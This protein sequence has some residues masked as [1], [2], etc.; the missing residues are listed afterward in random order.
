[1]NVWSVRLLALLVVALIAV[2]C[3]SVGPPA[4]GSTPSVPVSSATAAPLPT[5]VTTPV[6]TATPLVTPGVTPPP[7]DAPTAPPT[8]TSTTP[9]TDAPTAPPTEPPTDA[10][11]APPTATLAPTPSAEATLSFSTPAIFG[12]VNLQAGFVPDPH[13]MAVVGGG[14]ANV[15][16]LGD[17]CAGYTTTAPTYSVRYTS[18]SAALLRFYF[19]ADD[20]DASMIVNT[21]TGGWV[22][23]DDSFDTLDPTMDFNSPQGGRYD[24]WIADRFTSGTA[25]S[26][27]LN[28]TELSGNHPE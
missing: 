10:P 11:T 18:G 28:V 1:M 7:T 3:V 19:L 16:Y 25:L 27:S 17:N 24:I 23:V 12:L 14:T 22:C 13:A 15:F 20:G 4:T 21:P 8:A 2:G 26:G 5:G 6:P 9:P